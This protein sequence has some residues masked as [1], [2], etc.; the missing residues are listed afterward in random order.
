VIHHKV[1]IVFLIQQSIEK[2]N[3]VSKAWFKLLS[4]PI[5]MV[6]AALVMDF[7][8]IPTDERPKTQMKQ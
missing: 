1:L 2:T 3:F 5:K 7:I 6:L 8:R 4:N